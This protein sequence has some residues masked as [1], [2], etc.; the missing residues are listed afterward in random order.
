MSIYVHI[1]FYVCACKYVHQPR[2]LNNDTNNV[3]KLG[4]LAQ[5]NRK[6]NVISTA[7]IYIYTYSAEC[8]LFNSV[9]I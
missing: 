8:L 4:T 1:Y 7:N 5:L 3:T 6:T 2:A 9:L